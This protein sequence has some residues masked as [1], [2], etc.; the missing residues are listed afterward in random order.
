MTKAE[1]LAEAKELGLEADETMTNAVIEELIKN[2]KAELEATQEPV[3]DTQE[4]TQEPVKEEVK[5]VIYKI[6]C[7]NKDYTGV[8]ASVS[9]AGGKGETKDSHLAEWFKEKGYTVE[10]A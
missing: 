3:K 9:F 5:E 8:S 10:E 6:T 1:L 4:E 2:K 7:P